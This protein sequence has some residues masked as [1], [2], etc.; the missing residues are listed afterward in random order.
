MYQVPVTHSGS[1]CPAEESEPGSEA[2]SIM[3]Q[4]S[5]VE[6]H[7]GV[8]DQGTEPPDTEEVVD[9]QEM[10]KKP[11]ALSGNIEEAR[12]LRVVCEKCFE[13]KSPNK[14]N[15]AIILF[16]RQVR[17]APQIPIQRVSG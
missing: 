4:D 1:G 13:C 8:M 14:Y 2:V 16:V 5:D 11:K 6:T 7:G 12:R 3:D 17:V 10:R 9:S 15:T